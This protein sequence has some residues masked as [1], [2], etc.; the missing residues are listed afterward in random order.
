MDVLRRMS[1]KDFRGSNK[2]YGNCVSSPPIPNTQPTR[3]NKVYPFRP[4]SGSINPSAFLKG[5]IYQ[6][7]KLLKI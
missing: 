7:L 1:L 5:K 2:G 4:R 6:Y 3:N